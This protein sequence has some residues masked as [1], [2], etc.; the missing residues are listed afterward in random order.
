MQNSS[1]HEDQGGAEVG[2]HTGSVHAD[3][4]SRTIETL[5]DAIDNE[6]SNLATFISNPFY[7]APGQVWLIFCRA[8]SKH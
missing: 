6:D 1:A 2:V 5:R 3:A 4:A 7:A 8:G